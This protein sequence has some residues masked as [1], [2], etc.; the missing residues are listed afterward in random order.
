MREQ[1]EKPGCTIEEL[2]VTLGRPADSFGYCSGGQIENFKE[3]WAKDVLGGEVAHYFDRVSFQFCVS[4]CG[5][6]VEA[7]LMYGRGNWPCCK[8]CVKLHDRMNIK[9]ALGS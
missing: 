4:L 2:N 9:E 6:G 3:G 5:H 1:K 8:R 7:R